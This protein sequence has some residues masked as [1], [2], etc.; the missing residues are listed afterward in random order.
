MITTKRQASQINYMY[1]IKCDN[2]VHLNNN[3]LFDW[4]TGLPYCSDTTCVFLLPLNSTLPM[5]SNMAG[6]LLNASLIWEDVSTRN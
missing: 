6:L 5:D 4:Y 1:N 2:N 3:N